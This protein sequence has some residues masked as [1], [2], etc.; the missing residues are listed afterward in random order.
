MIRKLKYN[1]IIDLVFGMY[2]S[3]SCLT[4]KQT[5][6]LL[7]KHRGTL[8]CHLPQDLNVPG[9]NLDKYLKLIELEM[10]IFEIQN[11]YSD[12]QV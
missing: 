9:S 12:R 10:M 3:F 1:H 7:G 11:I 5:K 6:M 8:V 4:E 2:T